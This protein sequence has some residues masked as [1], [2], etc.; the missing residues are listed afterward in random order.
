MVRAGRARVQ[1]PPSPPILMPSVDEC[2]GLVTSPTLGRSAI[3]GL[4]MRS[5]YHP[6]FAVDDHVLSPTAPSLYRP[7]NFG[8]K[9]A[10]TRFSDLVT[11]ARFF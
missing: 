7:R 8:A 6:R 10:A 11:R 2:V 3:A 9:P 1:V 4:W 5:F